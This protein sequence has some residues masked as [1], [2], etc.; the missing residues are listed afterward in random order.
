MVGLCENSPKNS[1]G[2]RRNLLSNG[3]NQSENRALLPP[4]SPSETSD[5]CVVNLDSKLEELNTQLRKKEINLSGVQDMIVR[6]GRKISR[7][8]RSSRQVSRK[9]SLQSVTTSTISELFQRNRFVSPDGEFDIRYYNIPDFTERFYY[10]LF[11][12]LID[13]RWR[14]IA[15]MFSMCFIISWLVFGTLWWAIYMIRRTPEK[16]ISTVDSWTSAFLFSIETQTTIGYGGRAVTPDCPEGVILLIVQTIVGM[17]INCSVLGLMFT[18][19]ARPKNRKSTIV[20]AKKAVVSV[21]D[22]CLCLM[23]RLVDIRRRR[24]FDANLRAVVIKPNR[25]EEGEFIPLD[26]SD[27][28]LTIDNEQ[29]EY[30]MRLFP[31]FPLTVLHVIT[32][33]SPFYEMSRSELEQADFEIILILEGTVP[34][35]GMVTQALTSYRSQEII[36]G[37]RF[38]PMFNRKNIRQPL[39]RIDLSNLNDTYDDTITS[40]K[41]AKEL[42]EENSKDANRDSNGYESGRSSTTSVFETNYVVKEDVLHIGSNYSNNEETLHIDMN[43]DSMSLLPNMVESKA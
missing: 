32:E 20:F 22:G 35:T 4:S 8:V 3:T 30:T 33:G 41:S 36:W 12:T 37:H 31:I 27:L 19:A 23:F 14:W 43:E 1:M 40:S 34:T 9:N 13:A 28:E 18:K 2:I 6:G 5:S 38:R 16:C 10:D 11:H 24:L 25:T 26:M 15:V 42:D 39:N 21:R 29:V 17:F 7:S